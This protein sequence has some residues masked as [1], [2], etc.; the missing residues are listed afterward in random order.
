MKNLPEIITRGEFVRRVKSGETVGDVRLKLPAQFQGEAKAADTT[1]RQV[2]FTISTP[3]IDR[4]G[5]TIAVGG[6]KLDNYLRN[7]I[8][9]LNH[10]SRRDIGI[11]SRVWI[12]GDKLKATADFQESDISPDA[13][14]TY[15]KLIHPKR[16]LRAVSVGFMPL[17][18]AWSEASDRKYGIDFIEQELLEFS[19]VGI[20][21]NPEALADPPALQAGKSSAF[22]FELAQSRAS[23]LRARF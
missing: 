21:A 12:E 4:M 10:D 16:Y 22:L 6:W 1:E 11:A 13:D 3:T 14:R 23:A 9:L 15:R 19:V 20:P 5:D 17:K 8:V 7:P 2:S 18:W